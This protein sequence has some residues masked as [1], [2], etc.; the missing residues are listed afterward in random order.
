MGGWLTLWRDRVQRRHEFRRRQLDEFYAPFCALRQEIK[1]K[2]EVRVLMSRATEVEWEAELEG[3]SADR[4]AV[5]AAEMRPRFERAIAYNTA[6]FTQGIL[7]AFRKMLSLFQDK[8]PLV[9]ESTQAHCSARVEFVEVWNRVMADA[10]SRTLPEKIGHGEEALAGA[11]RRCGG[12]PRSAGFGDQEREGPVTLLR[13]AERAAHLPR[14][15]SG[16]PLRGHHYLGRKAGPPRGDAVR[17][18]VRWVEG[19]VACAFLR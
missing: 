9:E 3:L 7:P 1:A 16:G 14:V 5:V 19:R 11:V 18:I 2:G 12:P 8:L 6:Q 13:R 4:N 10:I 15:I 17:G